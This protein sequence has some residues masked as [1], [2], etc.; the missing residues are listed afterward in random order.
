MDDYG[1][2]YQTGA[3]EYNDQWG[4]SVATFGWLDN[5]AVDICL[6][7]GVHFSKLEV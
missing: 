6:M 1:N 3:W 7:I 5:L 4:Y 2:L